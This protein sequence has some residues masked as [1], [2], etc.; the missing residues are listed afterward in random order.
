MSYNITKETFFLLN[1][2]PIAYR[3]SNTKITGSLTAGVLLSQLIYWSSAV[4]D[5]EFYKTDSELIEETGL[6]EKEL[7]KAK[8]DII[9]SGVFSCKRKG[10]PAK[11]HWVFN[12]EEYNKKLY[13]IST[14]KR[15]ELEL[16]KGHLFECQKGG[17]LGAEKSVL[18]TTENTTE[19]NNIDT[20]PNSNFQQEK[21]QY[22]N[23]KN[24]PLWDQLKD[25]KF[26]NLSEAEIDLEIAQYSQGKKQ[27]I[28]FNA[29][30]FHLE[31]ANL[32]KLKRNKTKEW[33]NP[34]QTSTQTQNLN[35]KFTLYK[36]D[37]ATTEDLQNEINYYKSNHSDYE[38]VIV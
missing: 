2:R 1:E 14:D 10:L 11:N 3:K 33:Y 22:P 5:T 4:R 29:I 18:Y 36:K 28:S 13:L 9:D 37:F 34:A 19:N 26:P 35:K 21:N 32:N 38:L 7:L 15:A 30:I 27:S 20:K 24:N 25:N 17:T 31:S 16:T 8:K 12:I 23:L 6:T